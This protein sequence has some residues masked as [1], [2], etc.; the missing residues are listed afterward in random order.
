M[1]TC[2]PCLPGIA[3]E[4]LGLSDDHAT[5]TAQQSAAVFVESVR[6]TLDTRVSEIGNMEFDKDDALMMQF[7]TAASNLRSYCYGIPLQSLFFAKVSRLSIV[8]LSC[9]T[10]A[11][12]QRFYCSCI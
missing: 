9:L 3:C 1:I 5:W 4:A 6:R 8:F 2:H 11:F 10:S 12:C 7:V